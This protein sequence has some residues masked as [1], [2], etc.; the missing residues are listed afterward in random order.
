ME[1]T[2]KPEG[3]RSITSFYLPPATATQ[4]VLRSETPSHCSSTLAA[5]RGKTYHYTTDATQAP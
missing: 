4:V 5:Y 2:A 3:K 1:N